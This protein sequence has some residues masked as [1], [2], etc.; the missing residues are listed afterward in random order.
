MSVPR[1]R[2][3]AEAIEEL[4][5]DDPHTSVTPHFLRQIIA[6]GE[7]PSIRA[8]RKIL[9]NLDTLSTFLSQPIPEAKAETGIRRIGG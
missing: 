7:L 8:G 6:K 1:M 9:I 3:I 5:R 2:T 4:R